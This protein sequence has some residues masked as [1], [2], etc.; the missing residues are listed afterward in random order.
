MNIRVLPLGIYE[1]NCVILWQ[2]PRQAWLFDPGYEAATILAALKKENLQLGAIVLTHAHF[3]H[4][5]AVNDVLA[6][7]PAPV[8]LHT[9]DVPM[10]FSPMN[11]M[12]PYTSTKRPASLDNTKGDGDTLTCGGLTATFLHTPGHTPG[13]W[14]SYFIAEELMITGDTLFAGSIGRTDF[15]GGSMEDMGNSLRKLKQLPDAV[16]IICGHG[17]ESNL[18]RER[19]TNPYLVTRNLPT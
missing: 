18:A 1:A 5:S 4:I 7:Y 10:A 13:S 6:H 19:R 16:R 9:D 12:P 11:Q 3:D 2:D 15:P 14:C 8:Y 17:P